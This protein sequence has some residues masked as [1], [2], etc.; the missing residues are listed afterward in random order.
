MDLTEAQLT[1]LNANLE[2]VIVRDAKEMENEVA[3][4]VERKEREWKVKSTKLENMEDG[5]KVL[6]NLGLL[7]DRQNS[8]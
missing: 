1:A 3:T 2:G 4:Q 6:A 5:V 8:A 7:M